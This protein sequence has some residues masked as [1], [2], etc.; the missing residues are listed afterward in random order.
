MANP[1]DAVFE[2]DAGKILA[3]LHLAGQQ[4][5]PNS[6]PINTG[7]VNPVAKADPKNPGNVE[8]N[9][10]NKSGE[11]QFAVLKLL[12]YQVQIN[13]KKNKNLMKLQEN[14]EKAK[15]EDSKKKDKD[16]HADA[17]LTD[18]TKDADDKEKDKEEKV[19]KDSKAYKVQ[20]D[21]LKEFASYKLK[22]YKEDKENFAESAKSFNEAVKLENEQRKKAKEDEEDKLQKEAFEDIK[23][24][25]KTV[26]G[27]QNASKIKQTD[28]VQLNA[29]V[30]GKTKDPAQF[31][32]IKDFKITTK[33]VDDQIKK[34][35]EKIQETKPNDWIT[36]NI[37]FATCFTVEVETM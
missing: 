3:K 10:D 22:D 35:E 21:I 25:F 13:L 26:S 14:L 9:L 24:Y 6:I 8:F 15:K 28:I 20:Q 36:R 31:K 16:K 32:E 30:D 2:I 5:I 37:M 11:Y 29:D 17:K 12:K 19:D 1:N 27:D 34:Y 4:A 33:A 7:I 23:T 18:K